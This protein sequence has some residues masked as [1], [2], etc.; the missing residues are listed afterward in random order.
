MK[1]KFFSICAEG[2]AQAGLH[3]ADVSDQDFKGVRVLLSTTTS[4]LLLAN[5]VQI[6]VFCNTYKSQGAKSYV[7]EL[8]VRFSL[9][10]AVAGGYTL[11]S[12]CIAFQVTNVVKKMHKTHSCYREVNQVNHSQSQSRTRVTMLD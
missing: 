10:L 8:K 11:R 6:E 7:V 9:L 1:L 4:S 3:A 5:G 2:L 12:R